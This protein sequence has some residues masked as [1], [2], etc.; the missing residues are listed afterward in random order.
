[1][2]KKKILIT[3]ALVFLALFILNTYTIYTSDDI[4]YL[5]IYERPLPSSGTARVSSLGDLVKSIN[6]HYLMRN[7]RSLAHFLLQGALALG[8]TFFNIVNS[9]AFV[10][11]GIVLANLIFQS[12]KSRTWQAYTCLYC[13]LFLFIP[14]FGPAVLWKSGAANY[15]WMAIFILLAILAFVNWDIK[16]AFP[17][18][19]AI[20]L[21]ALAGGASENGAGMVI[22]VQALFILKWK[23]ER[24][25]LGPGPYIALFATCLGLA[26]QVLAPGNRIRA[27]QAPHAD[28]PVHLL[29]TLEKTWNTIG[30]FLVIYLGLFIFY[31]VQR[32]KPLIEGLIFVL[33]ALAGSLV[34]YFTPNL[35]ERS[36]LW[37]VLFM[38][39]GISYQ[40]SDLDLSLSKGPALIITLALLG[41]SLWVYKDAYI[42]IK[43]SYDQHQE[44]LMEI[45]AQ[46]AKGNKNP[47]VK[48]FDLPKN[49]YNPL[50]QTYHL[51][52]DPKYWFNQWFAYHYGLDS[53]SITNPDQA[54]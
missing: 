47:K 22:M 39:I 44:T 1:M 13:L 48:K 17:G 6:N 15:L 14:Q 31:L 50:A 42:S 9:L 18:L 49:T 34:L 28:L 38:I 7:G 4:T 54:R 52:E 8:P 2:T 43:T 29:L 25:R 26:Y 20:I 16:Q 10:I 36:W 21:A 37:P 35:A 11:L 27:G 12:P 41:A 32:K 30:I 46:V 45:E 23:W 5:Y 19:L 53:I 24:R 3:M 40:I 51:R 33:A